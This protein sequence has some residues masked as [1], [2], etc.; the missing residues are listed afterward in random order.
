MARAAGLAV[1]S[2]LVGLAG[3]GTDESSSAVEQDEAALNLSPEVN[4]QLAQ[5]RR[6]IAPFHDLETAQE[7]GWN[8][9]LTE[10]LELPGVGGMGIHYAN[11][12]FIDAEAVLLEPELLVYEPMKNG[13]LRLVAV[14]F[15]IPFS[16]VPADADP[17]T[18]LGQEFHPVPD[19]GIW[20]LHMWVFRHNPSGMFAD[21]N[22]KVSCEFAE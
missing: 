1:V 6:L 2:M 21:W 22:P 8:V 12:A 3:C 15:I 4:Q 20:G 10:C 13:K 18:L 9:R 11:P 14:E 7:A 5:L 19:A 16:E 17:P